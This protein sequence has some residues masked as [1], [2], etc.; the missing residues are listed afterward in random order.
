MIRQRIYDAFER[1]RLRYQHWKV[2]RQIRNIEDR[3][4]HHD[5]ALSEFGPISR[6]F[7]LVLAFRRISLEKRRAKLLYQSSGLESQLSALK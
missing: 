6:D 4:Y 3:I 7:S 5:G 2:S 1:I